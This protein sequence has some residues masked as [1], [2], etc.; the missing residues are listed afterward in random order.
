MQLTHGLHVPAGADRFDRSLRIWGLIPYQVKVSSTDTDGGL[1]VFEHVRMGRGGPP[2]HLHH[3]QDEWFYVTA[4]SFVFEVGD[5]RFTLGP[6]DSLFGPRGVPHVWACAGDEG[7]IVLGV[8]PAGTLEAFFAEACA[9]ATLPT[10]EEAARQFAAHG[11][12]VV[13]PPLDL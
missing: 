4:G 2:R 6:G 12:E 7:T 9:S 8:Q 13:G 5:D 1:F 10:P 3:A 11:M